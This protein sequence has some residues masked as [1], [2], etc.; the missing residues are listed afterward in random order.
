MAKVQTRNMND[1]EP[2]DAIKYR[3]LQVQCTLLV[4]VYDLRE[5]LLVICSKCYKDMAKIFNYRNENLTICIKQYP[6]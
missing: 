4:L 6:M 1:F 2:S 5:S 3:Q